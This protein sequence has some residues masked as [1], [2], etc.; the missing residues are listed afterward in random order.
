MFTN[1][2]C[3]VDG[4]EDS[5]KGAE[6]GLNLAKEF[7]GNITCVYVVT[8]DYIHFM[9]DDAVRRK[10]GAPFDDMLLEQARTEQIGYKV[11]ADI[12][13]MAQKVKCQNYTTKFLN[14]NPSD[15]L[16]NEICTGSYDLVIVGRQ[17]AS[18]AQKSLIG[19]VV[20][21]ILHLTT[22]ATLVVSRKMASRCA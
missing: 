3:C 12:I 6:M 7:D 22:V 1:I 8:E 9:K 14:G 5:A 11:F 19:N 20:E 13:A 17:A 2:L 21:A 16:V 18:K 15:E 4:S 10:A